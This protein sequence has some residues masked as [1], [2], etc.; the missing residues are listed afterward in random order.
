MRGQTVENIL[1]AFAFVAL[2]GAAYLWITREGTV[3]DTNKVLINDLKSENAQLVKRLKEIDERMEAQ[4]TQY[5]LLEAAQ[6]SLISHDSSMEQRVAAA[7]K[8]VDAAF[9][10]VNN[11]QLA[12]KVLHVKFDEL[13]VSPIGFAR[14]LEVKGRTY[15]YQGKRLSKVPTPLL[16]KSGVVRR[17]E[18]P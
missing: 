13:K 18:G 10:V 2:I 1:F 6:K 5:N 14:P 16:E 17:K 4:R 3:E 15:H 7:E 8:K 12:P 11:N 9:Q